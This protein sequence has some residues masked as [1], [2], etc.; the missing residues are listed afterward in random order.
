MNSSGYLH[1]A[2]KHNDDIK[3]TIPSVLVGSLFADNNIYQFCR[4]EACS[5]LIRA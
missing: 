4:A 1:S 2:N 3:I 5:S